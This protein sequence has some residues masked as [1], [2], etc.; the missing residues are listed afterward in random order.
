[1]QRR[2]RKS[3]IITLL[4]R[5][6]ALNVDSLNK[7]FLKT[8]L[9]EKTVEFKATFGYF[10][11]GHLEL[12]KY[13]GD[14]DQLIL[15]RDLDPV[16]SEQ[17]KPE[18]EQNSLAQVGQR[19][20]SLAAKNATPHT[21]AKNAS[22]PRNL[23]PS[24]NNGSELRNFTGETREGVVALYNIA[25]EDVADFAR[26]VVPY[27]EGNSQRNKSVGRARALQEIEKIKKLK[28]ERESKKEAEL[29]KLR[30][31]SAQRKKRAKIEVDR[32]K[33]ELGVADR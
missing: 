11:K 8:L 31:A 16:L 25:K 12:L 2:L 1:M 20:G 7:T 33:Q 27:T 19:N 10:N 18:R 22:K 30:K 15:D 24:S 14:P 26:Q 9:F 6:Q 5:L 13:Y 4:L 28:K 3:L 23:T 29:E 17:G 32:R 21:Q